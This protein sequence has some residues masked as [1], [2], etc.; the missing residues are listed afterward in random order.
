[1]GAALDM[2]RI[3]QPGS[4]ILQAWMAE[5][6]AARAGG[7]IANAG[8]YPVSGGREGSQL[9]EILT[10]GGVLSSAGVPVNERTALCVS[11]VYAAVGL[12]AGAISGLPVEIRDLDGQGRQTI[13]QRRS[14]P[15]A[16]LWWLLNEQPHD[17]FSS[18]VFWEW[19]TSSLLL[20]GDAFAIIRRARPSGTVVAL[21]PVH[22][23][24]VSVVDDPLD[25]TRLLYHVWSIVTEQV[26][27]IPQDDMLHVP[28]LGFDGYRGMSPVRMAGRTSI[29]IALAGDQY[30]A[31]VFRNGARPDFVFK[32]NA[33]MKPEQ[34]KA[35]REQW[36]EMHGGPDK[37]SLPGVLQGG[38]E[39]EKL[40]MSAADVQLIATRSFQIED[41][42]RLFGVPPH[43]IG[44]T[45]K[46]SAWGTGLEQL[47]RSFVTY[48]LQRHL[49]KFER[50][51]NRKLFP[52]RT[53]Y[54]ARFDVAELTR[55][56]A[57]ARA[58]YHRAALGGNNGP[59]WL[60]VDEVREREGYAP[61]GGEAEQL[62]TW[63][64]GQAAAGSTAE[65]APGE[66][67]EPPPASARVRRLE[68]G[69]YEVIV[70]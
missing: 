22:P 9:Y 39:I 43:M 12:I 68:N 33:Q 25:P 38:L 30:Q 67:S 28:G 31:A 34:I 51:L 19:L 36:T 62:V 53:R 8:V 23:T 46:A 70:G 6:T 63:K 57:K 45:E 48:T 47:G 41:I 29:G 65:S 24:A 61:I 10:G 15:T 21:E 69:E 66:G 59:G 37:A 3:R 20:H 35:L 49:T 54:V 55:G 1:M 7:R 2:D 42:A 5:R 13:D 50:E 64:V 56:D 60:T 44:Q 26:E 18:A 14:G 16:S 40:S 27:A 11:A 58:D 4:T 17:R 32:T 52:T